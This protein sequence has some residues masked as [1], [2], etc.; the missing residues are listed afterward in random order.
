MT[1]LKM[2]DQMARHETKLSANAGSENAGPE[3]DEP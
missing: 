3:N 1:D 2:K